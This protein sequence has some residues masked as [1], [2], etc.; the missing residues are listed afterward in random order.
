MFKEILV[1]FRDPFLPLLWRLMRDNLYIKIKNAPDFPNSA[2]SSKFAI[3]F[4]L[5][6][7]NESLNEL[8]SLLVGKPKIINS[9]EI[10]LCKKGKEINSQFLSQF[11]KNGSDKSTTHSYHPIYSSLI[12]NSNTPIKAILEIGIGTNNINLPSNMGPKGRPG[13]SLQSWQEL[14]PNATIVGADIDKDILIFENNIKSFLLDQTSNKSWVKFKEKLRGLQ[15]DLIIDDG[16]HSPL[17]NLKTI[18][19]SLDLLSPSGVLVIEDIAE[20]SLPYWLIFCEIGMEGY[21]CQIVQAGKCYLFLL[22]KCQ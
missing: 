14:F 22:S 17:S 6:G 18:C 12:C 9:D 7:I 10:M 21:K 11:S 19:H 4:T 1:K 15:F 2:S 5:R 3:D 8:T 16:L 13:A 20:R